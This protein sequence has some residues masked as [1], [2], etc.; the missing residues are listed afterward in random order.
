MMKHLSPFELRQF[1]GSE[2]WYRHGLVRT[3]VFTDGANWLLDT[4]ALSQR[5]EKSGCGRA[6]PGLSVRPDSTATLTCDDGN[7]NTVYRQELAFTD[8]PPEG[9]QLYCTDKTILLP[10]EY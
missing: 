5:S 10:S 4:I 6:V 7:H 9:I 1:T 8:F 2:H 3:V